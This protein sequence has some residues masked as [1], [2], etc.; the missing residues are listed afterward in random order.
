M[1]HAEPADPI[2]DG[3]LPAGTA[4]LVDLDPLSTIEVAGLL[5]GLTPEQRAIARRVRDDTVSGLGALL[6]GPVQDE[7]RSDGAQVSSASWVAGYLAAAP[8]VSSWMRDRAVPDDVIA[9]TLGDLG[10]H[11]RL[12]RRH[13]GNVG[14]DAPQWLG[15][16]LS[17]GLYQLGRL[18]FLLRR[19]RPDEDGLPVGSG[20]WVLDVHIPEAG[21]LTP[22]VVSDSFRRAV[23]FFDRHFPG[24]PAHLA[25]CSSWLL[26][27]YLADHLP[28]SSNIVAF[29][30]RFT[31]F[32]AARDDELDAL[33]FT[34]GARTLDALDNLP[35]NSALQRVVL[36][37]IEAAGRWQVVSGLCRL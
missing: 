8:V 33:Y 17:G 29:Q 21:P 12:H 1:H 10:R 2:D 14:L 35:R 24:Q 3:V 13:T 34:F 31:P 25:V 20:P 4:A 9:A 26:D 15:A 16:V 11:L 32:G 37:R 30:R 28:A 5:A 6:A 22:D 36:D 27:P 18:Q 7:P 19:R 23:A